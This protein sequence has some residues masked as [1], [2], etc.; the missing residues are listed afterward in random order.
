MNRGWRA[1]EGCYN[2]FMT[3]EQEQRELEGGGEGCGVQERCCVCFFNVFFFLFYTFYFEG[4][5][6]YGRGKKKDNISHKPRL[7]NY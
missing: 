6:K 4:L 3:S 2:V 7:G 1:R 5:K